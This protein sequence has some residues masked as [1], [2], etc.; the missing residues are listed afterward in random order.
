VYPPFLSLHI[1]RSAVARLVASSTTRRSTRS[2][3]AAALAR[4]CER[5]STRNDGRGP[6]QAHPNGVSSRRRVAP[7]RMHGP[8]PATVC[9]HDSP[10]AARVR[11][12]N[13]RPE[14]AVTANRTGVL[15][16]PLKRVGRRSPV[17]TTRTCGRSHW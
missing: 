12:Q 6:P 7:R 2:V 15:R 17:R 3:R 1:A 9:S 10:C 4:V 14:V 5:V 8:E 11:L 16:P 13:A